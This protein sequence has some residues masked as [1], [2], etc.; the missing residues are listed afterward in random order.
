MRPGIRPLILILGL[1]PACPLPNAG[2]SPFT[3]TVVMLSSAESTG[4]GLGTTTDEPGTST[5]TTA[6]LST[7]AASSDTG[8]TTLILDVGA[9]HDLGDG[10]PVGCKGK[11][12]FLFVIS[13]YAGMEGFQTQLRDAFP[14]FIDTIEAKFADFDYHIMVVDGDPYWGLSTC[15]EQCPTP[16]AG[17]CGV[18]DYPCDYTP[19]YCDTKLGAG[20]VFPAGGNAVNKPCNIDGDR[21]YMVTG[22]TDLKK[23]FACAAQVGSSGSSWVAEAMVAALHSNINDPGGCNPD[24]LRKDA[25]LMVTLISNT[26]DQEGKPGGSTGTPETWT[27]AV[28]KAKGDDMRSVVLL[29]IGDTM[30]PGCHSEDRVCQMIKMFPFGLTKEIWEGDYGPFFDEATDLVETAC[31]DFVPPQ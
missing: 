30:V 26:Y 18:T 23:T 4:D 22:Q 7:G 24:F 3:T 25:L 20:T 5:S 9:D 6:E 19:T 11:I 10:K 1:T 16:G 17:L 31:A 14:K 21:R 8:A 27:T 2:S 12:D 29:N 15:D 13:R 28:R